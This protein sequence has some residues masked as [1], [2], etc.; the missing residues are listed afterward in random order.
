MRVNGV[1]FN[2]RVKPGP[3]TGVTFANVGTSRP[4]NNGAISVSFTAPA[5]QGKYPVSSY[6]ANIVSGSASTATGSSSPLTITNLSS[7][8]NLQ[9]RI[10]A[11]NVWGDS[12][13]V[14]SSSILVTTVPQAPTINSVTITYPTF[15][16]AFTAGA[17]G[18]TSI[19][20]YE[21]STNGGTNWKALS[22]TTSP[23]TVSTQSNNSAF[24]A[25]VTY[26]FTL[27]AINANGSS[28]ASAA[29]NGT[30]AGTPGLP[31]T[32]T[33]K[34]TYNAGAASVYTKVTWTAAANNGS[35]ITSY[36]VTASPGGA[37]QTLNA[38]EATFTAL[39][40]GTSYT[41][42]VY[43][44]NA[45]GNG[46]TAASNSIYAI[47]IGYEQS[48]FGTSTTSSTYQTVQTMPG[49]AITNKG[50]CVFMWRGTVD[51]ASTTSDVQSRLVSGGTG[52]SSPLVPE[53]TF[54]TEPQDTTD[55]IP[56]GGLVSLPS[57]TSLDSFRI[58][59][60]SENNTSIVNFLSSALLR[61]RLG[62]NSAAARVSGSTSSSANAFVTAVGP[63]FPVAGN[64]LVIASAEI[65]NSTTSASTTIVRTNI[66]TFNGFSWGVLTTHGVQ[67]TIPT[68]DVTN[69][70]PYFHIE[71]VNVATGGSTRATVSITAGTT[72]ITATARNVNIMVLNLDNAAPN[73][74][75]APASQFTAS[76]TP[77]T[78]GSAAFSFTNT[79]NL[80]L[81]MA[82][83]Q[84]H[85]S[86]TSFSTTATFEQSGVGQLGQTVIQEPNNVNEEFP[87]IIFKVVQGTSGTF[88]FK[89]STETGGSGASLSHPRIFA[90]DLGIP[91]V[92]L[93]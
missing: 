52:G 85:G 13:N 68:V 69:Y 82:Y 12:T 48:A 75:A 38:L 83:A 74:Y 46:S 36:T 45:V 39:T 8:V 41:F 7:G 56:I 37:S 90:M 28:L 10:Y 17:T 80:H 14:T 23:Q 4:Y 67:G 55:R 54:N 58:Q 64:Y 26:A 93:F 76:T 65:N 70:S 5:N 89:L 81:V 53:Q 51:G 91:N 72:G 15:S 18:G 21:Y 62:T 19:T 88:N 49:S 35:S 33:A 84:V 30:Y 57:F 77:V 24:V 61:Y 63:T 9:S 6:T 2:G 59:I 27:R 31:G 92:E 78:A 43:A 3:P 11:T 20:S 66:E 32:V 47:D 42:S 50:A 29:V 44:T 16:M 25:G 60:A 73:Y 86:S 1:G 34:N 71:K 22:G 79:G 87:M 40:P